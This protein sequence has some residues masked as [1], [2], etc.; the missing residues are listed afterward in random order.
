MME[1]WELWEELPAAIVDDGNQYRINIVKYD[2][3]VMVGYK[4]IDQLHGQGF[5]HSVHGNTLYE[6]FDKMWL[7][8]QDYSPNEG[9]NEGVNKGLSEGVKI[10]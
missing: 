8:W 7:W 5:L 1:L 9:L 2:T 10:K 6:A 3:L 4:N